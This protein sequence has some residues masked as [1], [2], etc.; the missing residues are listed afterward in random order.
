MTRYQNSQPAKATNWQCEIDV[1][2]GLEP[3]AQREIDARLSRAA[4][5]LSTRLG[6]VQFA[7]SG[8][9]R[10]LLELRSALAA[11]IS[12][13]FAVPRPRALLGHAH[14]TALAAAVRQVIGLHPAGAFTT[15]R[16]SAAG[17]DSAVLTRLKQE[18]A[19]QLGLVIAEEADLLLRLRRGRKEGWEVLVRISPRPLATRAWR[20]CNF[21]GAP[22]ATLGYAVAALTR[23][24]PADRVLNICCGSGTLLAERLNGWSAARAIGCDLDGHA[25]ACADANL[26]AAGLRRQVQLERWDATAMP[27]NTA[28]VDVIIADL[29]FGQLV[30]SHDDNRRLYPRLLSEAARVAA[31]G[32]R[33]ALLTHELRLLERAQADLADLWAIE[34]MVRVRSGGMTPGIF[35]M[36]RAG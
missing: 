27:L 11:Y 15:M 6:A 3:L 25:L 12:L 19:S 17:D 13:T 5:G 31:P 29:P 28:S 4:S 22:N 20:V 10:A 34:S 21:P 23:P 36:R 24:A 33:M 2:E 32:A 14:L 8:E 9:L 35:L 7:Y 18:L 16:L 26:Q 1:L 30:G